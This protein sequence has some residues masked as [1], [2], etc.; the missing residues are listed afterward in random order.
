MTTA[1]AAAMTSSGADPMTTSVTSK[2]TQRIGFIGGGQMA[3]ALA[4]G[5]MASGLVAP[6][7]VSILS[8]STLSP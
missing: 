1:A 4:K 8:F 3:L 6:G 2:L 5:F 7:Q